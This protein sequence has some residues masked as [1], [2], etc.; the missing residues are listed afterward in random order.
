MLANLGAPGLGSAVGWVGSALYLVTAVGLLALALRGARTDRVIDAALDEGLGADWRAQVGRRL[1]RRSR[2]PA[3]LG[4][5]SVPWV[6]GRRGVRRIANLSYGEA[7]LHNRLDVY[8]G[9]GY[10][11][12]APVLIHLHGGML[13]R[14]RK[15]IEARTLLYRLA[16]EGWVCISANAG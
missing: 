8:C 13:I 12:G 11:E 16:A 5:F 10:V 14:G 9:R 4:V 1:P 15:N 6:S 2:W 3:W 7:G